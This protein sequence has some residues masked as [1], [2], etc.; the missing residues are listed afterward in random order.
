[1]SNKCFPSHPEKASRSQPLV[2][3]LEHRRPLIGLSGGST[4]PFSICMLLNHCSSASFGVFPS[5]ELQWLL[6]IFLYPNCHFWKKKMKIKIKLSSTRR[7]LTLWSYT[8]SGSWP[9]DWITNVVKRGNTWGLSKVL[10]AHFFMWFFFLC[11]F[12]FFF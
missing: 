10:F 1:M 4:F 2:P 11:G 6:I 9:L 8:W 7:H 3:V 5:E 12:F